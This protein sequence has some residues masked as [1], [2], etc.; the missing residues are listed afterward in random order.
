MGGSK[1]VNAQQYISKP[2]SNKDMAIQMAMQN[3]QARQQL[4]QAQLLNMSSQMPP[5]Q[6][7]YDPIKESKRLGEIGMANIQRSRELEKQISPEAAAMRQAQGQEIAALTSP[8]EASKYINE[9][10]KKQGLIQGF[11]TGLQDSTIGKAATYD[12]ALQA[13]RNREQQNIALQQQVLQQMQAPVGGIDPASSIAAQ[14]QAQGQNLQSMQNWQNAMYGNIGGYNQSV[15]DQM[16]QSG[17]NFQN[18]QQ[19]AAQNRQNYMNTMLG[20]QS[21]NQAGKNAM[22]GAYV[23]AAGSVIGGAAGGIGSAYKN[24]GSGGGGT[25]DSTFGKS[26]ANYMGGD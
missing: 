12:A 25:N 19:S 15:A 10:S 2:S 4:Q 21:Q 5:E 9:W 17:V 18:M 7:I 3:A 6:Q 1:T 14:Q 23:G 24:A 8:E 20:V 11:E 26:S 22:T 13:K 16:A